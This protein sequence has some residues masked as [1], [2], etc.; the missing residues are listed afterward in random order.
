MSHEISDADLDTI[1]CNNEAYEMSH[2]G[3]RTTPRRLDTSGV[4][5]LCGER[6]FCGRPH[7]DCMSR[8]QYIADL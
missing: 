4:C 5:P 8:E 2:F 6:S 7:Y 1:R 3:P